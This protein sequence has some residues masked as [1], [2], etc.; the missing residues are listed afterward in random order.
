MATRDREGVTRL[1]A[2]TD[3]RIARTLF[4]SAEVSCS[5]L[6]T[7]D[8]PKWF[9]GRSIFSIEADK[10]QLAVVFVAMKIGPGQRRGRGLLGLLQ[11]PGIIE[12]TQSE[13]PLRAGLRFTTGSLEHGP[14]NASLHGPAAVLVVELVERAA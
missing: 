3:Y 9:A 1:M 13:F 12:S 7:L 8:S 14:G 6:Q 2:K 4:L 10:S 11:C 5:N